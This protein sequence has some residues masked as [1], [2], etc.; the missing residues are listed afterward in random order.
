MFSIK[1]IFLE[2]ILDLRKT[3]DKISLELN[4]GKKIRFRGKIIV[5]YKIREELN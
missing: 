4:K 3:N 1:I 5:L 2:N